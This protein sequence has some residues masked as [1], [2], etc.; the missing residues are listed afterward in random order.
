MGKR[1]SGFSNIQT[2]AGSEREAEQETQI[3][4]ESGVPRDCQLGSGRKAKHDGTLWGGGRGS[5]TVFPKAYSTTGPFSTLLPDREGGV[6]SQEAAKS[7]R[8]REQAPSSRAVP[9]NSN[10]DSWD[11]CYT[12]ALCCLSLWACAF[13]I[14]STTP[15]FAA[16]EMRVESIKSLVHSHTDPKVRKCYAHLEPLGHISSWLLGH[17]LLL[18]GRQ[19]PWRAPLLPQAL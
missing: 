10:K 16:Q 4:Q 3:G 9:P 13:Y 5:F 18:P 19:T 15:A 1:G 17:F 7:P 2:R 11:L 6:P 14:C 8:P 12:W